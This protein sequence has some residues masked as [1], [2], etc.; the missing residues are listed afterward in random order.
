PPPLPE[1]DLRTCTLDDTKGL[2][3]TAF[4][5]PLKNGA[6]PV[7]GFAGWFDVSFRG[8]DDI[9][10][11]LKPVEFSTSPAA[12]YTHWGQQVGTCQGG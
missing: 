12:G 1:L 8:R 4:S 10:P 11:L 6:P 9:A 2:G 5:F 7:T 3:E